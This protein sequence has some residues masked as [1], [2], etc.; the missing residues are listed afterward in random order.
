MF[1]SRSKPSKK[2]TQTI[3]GIKFELSGQYQLVELIGMGSFGAVA[4]AR[5]MQARELVAVKK[6]APPTQSVQRGKQLLRETKLM[7]LLNHENILRIKSIERSRD[8]YIVT[9]LMET[10]LWTAVNSDQPISSDA[11]QMVAYQMFR[12]LEYM[13]K[14]HII[15]RDL[16]PSNILL[17][18]DC[19][20]KIA[21]LGLARK[22]S[23]QLAEETDLSEYV[24][25]RWYRSPEIV[26]ECGSYSYS[27]DVWAAGCILAEMALGRPLLPGKSRGGQA[28]L[29]FRLCGRPKEEEMWMIPSEYRD[30]IRQL[31]LTP[32]LSVEQRL[33]EADPLLVDLLKSVLVLDPHK[34]PSAEQVL[35]HPYFEAVQDQTDQSEAVPL[36]DYDF[37]FESKTLTKAMVNDLLDQEISLY[38]SQEA[39]EEYAA[40]KAQFDQLV[41]Q[42]TN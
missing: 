15:H 24:V 41:N 9:E 16:K 28:N 32:E 19:S 14:A 5:D 36:S 3:D 4:V 10:D 7:R 17:N 37:V 12:G 42:P 21:D 2:Q 35:L 34:R 40:Q 8:I 18:N 20:V 31:P 33:S 26:L 6:V 38:H 27:A 22:V 39:C 29:I 30:L 11:C 25:S 1:F 23:S 13:H